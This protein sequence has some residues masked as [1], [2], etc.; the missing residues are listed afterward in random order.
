MLVKIRKSNF[1]RRKFLVFKFPDSK[2]YEVVYE[3]DYDYF[4]L[5]KHGILFNTVQPISKSVKNIKQIMYKYEQE[6]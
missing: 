3:G 6:K 1:K 2:N 5:I 4:I